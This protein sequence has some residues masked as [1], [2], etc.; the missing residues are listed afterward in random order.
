MSVDKVERKGFEDKIVI[1]RKNEQ[2]YG[3]IPLF[4]ILLYLEDQPILFPNGDGFR[5]WVWT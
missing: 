4:L 2:F 5:G 3:D 1:F